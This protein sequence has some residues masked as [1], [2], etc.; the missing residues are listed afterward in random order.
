LEKLREERRESGVLSSHRV[1]AVASS[2]EERKR[3]SQE[4]RRK[5][6]PEQQTDREEQHRELCALRSLRQKE[7]KMQLR[8]CDVV[9]GTMTKWQYLHR[10]LVDDADDIRKGK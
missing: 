1:T 8:K 3:G 2:I 5:V 4:V 9:L 6:T 10:R 7:M